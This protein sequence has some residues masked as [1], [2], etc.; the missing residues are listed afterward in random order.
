M[1]SFFVF[2]V[3]FLYSIATCMPLFHDF[4]DI[5]GL[6]CL[7]GPLWFSFSTSFSSFFLPLFL[8]LLLLYHFIFFSII[9]FQSHNALSWQNIFSTNAVTHTCYVLIDECNILKNDKRI[10]NKTNHSKVSGYSPKEK[11]IFEKFHSEHYI[12]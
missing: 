12:V 7:L 1:I 11:G 2:S 10:I 9:C 8:L 5:P 3:L 4:Q 6:F